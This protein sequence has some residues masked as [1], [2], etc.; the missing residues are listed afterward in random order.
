MADFWFDAN[1]FIPAQ[2]DKNFL[3][4]LK[5]LVRAANLKKD[6]Y[7][8][9]TTKHITKEIQGFLDII[10]LYFITIIVDDTPEF[11]NFQ[12]QTIY[13]I[14]RSKALG[15]PADCSLAYQASL[16]TTRCF[17]VSNDDGFQDIKKD[18][19]LLIKNVEVIEPTEFFKMVM[20]EI[21][22]ESL[23]KKIQAL[24]IHYADYFIRYRLEH[25]W[26]YPR[27]ISRILESLL[28]FSTAPP[29]ILA[30]LEEEPEK[31]QKIPL[32]DKDR[33]LLDKL[34]ANQSLNS[35]ELLRLKP[36]QEIF[37]PFADYYNSLNKNT[38]KMLTKAL[39]LKFP[40]I[41][42]K[43]RQAEPETN[44][45]I[46]NSSSALK[47][48]AILKMFEIRIKETI[49][50]FKECDFN[51]AFFHF[52]TL[53]ES[54]WNINLSAEKKSILKFLYGIFLLNV[55]DFEFFSYIFEV[56]YWKEFTSLNQIF[57]FLIGLRTEK[58]A[59]DVNTLPIQDLQLIYNL[60]LYF[61]NTNNP[62]G[63]R[64]FKALFELNA[65]TL[66]SLEW[67][68]DFLKCHLLELR[69]RQE[70][71]SDTAEQKFLGFLSPDSFKDHTRAPFDSS[72]EVKEFT[73]VES[74]KLLF[75]QPF[76]FAQESAPL[77]G[78][79]E[80]YCWNDYIRSIVILLVPEKL[81]VPYANLKTIA[82]KSGNIKTKGVPREKKQKARIIIVLDEDCKLDF[83]RFT[84][85]VEGI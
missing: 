29:E 16:S 13:A 33:T 18:L 56:G 82:I 84:L 51:E 25:K 5:E 52:R 55:Q 83:Q 63:L 17:V 43:L 67:H 38:H 76:Y 78:Y 85:D 15:E 3:T 69:I 71:I 19:P 50:Y 72:S 35:I 77:N 39:Y 40:E 70:Q 20:L 53:L 66:K 58:T 80:L 11:R 34:L 81:W 68:L 60:G 14:G 61:C 41:L 21:E 64:I 59:M 57:S 62:L 8:L 27:P 44:E 79:R 23:K 1:F 47:K 74:T 37:K 31:E 2:G 49:S 75:S 48:I 26:K 32:S 36:V 22:D 42:L 12:K 24:I 6:K 73:P 65:D 54:D 4:T 10:H 30:E 46:L 9:K 7:I 45:D 28:V